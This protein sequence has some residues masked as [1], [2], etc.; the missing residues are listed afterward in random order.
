MKSTKEHKEAFSGLGIVH[1]MRR[2]NQK[3]YFDSEMNFSANTFGIDLI[4]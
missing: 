4:I 2:S 3:I 1:L